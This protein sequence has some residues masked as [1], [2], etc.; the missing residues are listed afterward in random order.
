MADPEHLKVFHRG[1]SAWNRWRRKH[2]GLQPDLSHADLARSNLR[3]GN[4]NNANLE[5]ANL[6]G[7]NFGR[8]YLEAADLAGAQQ[9]GIHLFGADLGR[10]DLRRADLGE[11]QLWHTRL[12]EADLR[13][14]C[15]A[16]ADLRFSDLSRADLRGADLTDAN[17]EGVSLFH[18]DLR[19][20]RLAGA[21][22]ERLQVWDSR[23]EDA[24]LA[25]AVMIHVAL[26]N[27]DLS[28]TR[29]LA[30][31]RHDQPSS[32]GLDTLERTALGLAHDGYLTG[33]VEAFFRGAGVRESYLEVFRQRIGK[34]V[35]FYSAFIRHSQ[36]DRRF[37]RRLYDALQ[38]RGVR[39]WLHEHPMLPGDDAHEVLDLGP[40]DR[41]LLCVSEAACTSWWIDVEIARAEAGTLV[42]VSLDAYLAS[43]RWRSPESERLRPL[44]AADFDGWADDDGVFEPQLE[45]VMAALRVAG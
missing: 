38:R 20:A 42:G 26:N 8:A 18:A 21:R 17:L 39:C 37:A 40:W 10:A 30:A 22:L 13:E 41:L 5:G 34:P 14:A 32:I 33:E 1:V 28:R 12:A 27:V 11:A 36:A 19:G 6:E 35:G 15:L 23:F 9:R 29:S 43:G 2:R 4:L 25:A 16:S 45:R 24:D 44:L 3:L 31:V 7:A